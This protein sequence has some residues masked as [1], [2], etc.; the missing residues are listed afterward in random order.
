MAPQLP[1]AVDGKEI[2]RYSEKNTQEDMDMENPFLVILI[3]AVCIVVGVVLFGAV[4][5]LVVTR[6]ALRHARKTMDRYIK[7]LTELTP[8]ANCGKCGYES[9]KEYA[10][11]MVCSNV[12]ANLCTYGDETVTE[13]LTECLA[14]FLKLVEPEEK[15]DDSE[16]AKETSEI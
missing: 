7:K 8:G 13:N 9:C 10:K 14:E 3:A 15:K 16:E 6:I 2:L 5:G 12:E 11:A 1:T 4:L